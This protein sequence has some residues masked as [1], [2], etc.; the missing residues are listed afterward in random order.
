[1]A[2]AAEALSPEAE[3]A[4]SAAA[5]GHGKRLTPEVA[6]ELR[7][8]A[9]RKPKA[10]RSSSNSSAGGGVSLPSPAG[11]VRAVGAASSPGGRSN[12]LAKLILAVVLGIGAL[13]VASSVSGQYFDWS[14]GGQQAK[15][16]PSPAKRS[17]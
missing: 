16:T 12:I 1:M 15:P 4:V 11:A 5:A 3:E 17:S 13:E 8:R 2:I 9:S 6:K 7:R 14:F 10:A